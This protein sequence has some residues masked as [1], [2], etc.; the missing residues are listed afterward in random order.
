MLHNYIHIFTIC[1]LFVFPTFNSNKPPIT[2]T[3]SSLQSYA[4]PNT[5]YNTIIT[6]HYI[7]IIIS[8]VISC[9]SS[10]YP[11]HIR[12]VTLSWCTGDFTCRFLCLDAARVVMIHEG[13]MAPPWQSRDSERLCDVTE[14]R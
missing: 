8:V 11:T 5:Q 3:Y 4:T 7:S 6:T 9:Y 2:D 13:L 12:H 10:S 1:L 14:H